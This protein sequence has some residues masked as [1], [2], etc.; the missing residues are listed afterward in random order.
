MSRPSYTRPKDHRNLLPTPQLSDTHTDSPSTSTSIYI[1]DDNL[2]ETDIASSYVPPALLPSQKPKKKSLQVRWHPSVNQRQAEKRRRQMMSAFSILFFFSSLTVIL[3]HYSGC[4][5]ATGQCQQCFGGLNSLSSRA[6]RPSP[7]KKRVQGPAKLDRASAVF[8]DSGLVTGYVDLMPEDGIHRDHTTLSNNAWNLPHRHLTSDQ[9]DTL[10]LGDEH[11]ASTDELSDQITIISSSQ[12]DPNFAGECC[13]DSYVIEKVITGDEEEGATGPGTATKELWS[14]ATP[15]E[16]Y[17]EIWNEGSVALS[18]GDYLELEDDYVVVSKAEEERQASSIQNRLDPDTVYMTYLPNAGFS[19]QFHGMLRAAML[20]K[21]LGRTLI[22]PPLTNLGHGNSHQNQPWSSYFDL[23]TFMYLT[24]SKVIELQTVREPSR[25]ALAFESLRC[26]ITGGIGSLR[27]FDSTAKEFLKQWKFEF[28]E[29][30]P[31]IETSNFHELQLALQDQVEEHLLCITNSYSI[32]VPHKKDW[33]EF[34]RHLY[35]TPSVERMFKVILDRLHKEDS[36]RKMS[37]QRKFV[38]EHSHE[39]SGD[40]QQPQQDQYWD[41][42]SLEDQYS[43]ENQAV[44]GDRYD[45]GQINSAIVQDI[46]RYQDAHN[47]PSDP[48]D[49]VEG[50]SIPRA[51][52]SFISIHARRGDI[53][54][55]CQ[56]SFQ[57]SLESCLPTTQELASRLHSLFMTDQTLRG[58]PVYVSTKEDRPEEL[59]EFE[60]LGWHV[61]DHHAMGSGEFGS[62]ILDQM[63]MA[64]GQAMIGVRTSSFS[65]LGA[66]RQEDWYGRKA[67]LM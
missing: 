8:G 45:N 32:T 12:S 42:E 14:E 30:S 18:E 57:N 22:L 33:D 48:T 39:Q 5:I 52:N 9:E 21:A 36:Q 60:A 49:K 29:S 34:G 44:R 47:R 63:F 24:G 59:A 66:Y 31:Q 28:E 20:A 35:F 4:E 46:T 67:V 2:A 43:V 3:F 51:A 7:E 26:H 10:A 56:Q 55:Y 54:E 58:L 15:Q 1:T 37:E 11:L 65:R 41:S 38:N 27:P 13:D 64:Q 6:S 17:A 16:T 50:T 53:M 62:I 25:I 23:D 61:L 19:S 40:D